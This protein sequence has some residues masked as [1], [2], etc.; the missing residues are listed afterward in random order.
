M[1]DHRQSR[2][3]RAFSAH[4]GTAGDDGLPPA[5]ASERFA[6]AEGGRDGCS[7]RSAR[8]RPTRRRSPSSGWSTRAS[9]ASP[10]W[11]HPVAC[12]GRG[13]RAP[14][15]GAP[16][17]ASARGTPSSRPRRRLAEY[18]AP[19]AVDPLGAVPGAC[20]GGYTHSNGPGAA[21]RAESRWGEALARTASGGSV[22][23]ARGPAGGLDRRPEGAY[24]SEG[25]IPHRPRAWHIPNGHS[26]WLGVPAL[27]DSAATFAR[28]DGAAQVTKKARKQ[29]GNEDVGVSSRGRGRAR[30]RPSRRCAVILSIR[31]NLARL[32]ADLDPLG[33]VVLD[34]GHEGALR[35][36]PSDVHCAALPHS[37]RPGH[38]S[39][40]AGRR[41]ASRSRT[42]ASPRRSRR[43]ASTRLRRWP[44]GAASRSAASGASRCVPGGPSARGTRAPGRRWHGLRGTQCI[45]GRARRCAVAQMAA[46]RRLS[47]WRYGGVR[48]ARQ[49]GEGSGC[50]RAKR[51]RAEPC[52]ADARGKLRRSTRHRS[53]RR[54]G[55]TAG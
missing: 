4:R 14:R 5:R 13:A 43:C 32:H 8:A 42:R 26:R 3:D 30:K 7:P 22:A 49:P 47:A 39:S 9:E 46:A 29:W 28:R 37:A 44:A 53:G 2:L 51:G 20:V 15:A 17:E 12:D 41:S 40:R 25:P 54:P 21:S 1:C 38:R 24:G 45:S 18:A 31:E 11:G 16:G 52:A 34:M 27:V 50:T 55:A 48:R 36:C 19:E 10:S 33:P 35:Y 6:R 23:P